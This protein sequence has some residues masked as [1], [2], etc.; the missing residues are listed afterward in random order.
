VAGLDIVR[1]HEGRFAVLEDNARTPSGLAYTVAARALMNACP[2]T[3]PEGVRPIDDVF[4]HLDA[5]L[6]AT[7]P[8]GRPDPVLA[9]LTVGP[10]P[11]W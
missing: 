1:D 7:A 2:P 4:A 3:P 5:A 10:A 8:T 6:R 9:L 11:S